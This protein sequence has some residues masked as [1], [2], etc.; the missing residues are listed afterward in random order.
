MQ[1]IKEK[2]FGRCVPL[3]QS[4]L[5]SLCPSDAFFTQSRWDSVNV[6]TFDIIS[7]A[8]KLAVV[9]NVLIQQYFGIYSDINSTFCLEQTVKFFC[10]VCFPTCDSDCSGI[11]NIC[12]SEC[13]SL[14]DHGCQQIT[15]DMFRS[16]PINLFFDSLQI[17]NQNCTESEQRYLTSSLL[18]TNLPT[19]YLSTF[20]SYSGNGLCVPSNVN[21]ERNS[22][23]VFDPFEKRRSNILLSNVARC[24]AFAFILSFGLAIAERLRGWNRKFYAMKQDSYGSIYALQMKRLDVVKG[25]VIVASSHL[26]KIPCTITSIQNVFFPLEGHSNLIHIEIFKDE[27]FPTGTKLLH[28]NRSFRATED[29]VTLFSE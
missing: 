20:D 8:E 23:I 22:Q 25:F 27:S 16:E 13:Q 7:Y 28:V 4:S 5:P 9:K 21:G 10:G 26:P 18:C 1:E 6:S 14:I 3:N 29:V 12:Q 15:E 17:V 19:R 2:D 11:L 24:L